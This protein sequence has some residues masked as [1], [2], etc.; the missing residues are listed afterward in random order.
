MDAAAPSEA[1]KYR[2]T[3]GFK[4]AEHLFNAQAAFAG[5]TAQLKADMPST[6][7]L[8]EGFLDALRLESLGQHA[9][10]LMG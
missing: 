2:L 6:L 7:Y 1:P 9:V 4:K 5:V 3:P 8:V 10:A